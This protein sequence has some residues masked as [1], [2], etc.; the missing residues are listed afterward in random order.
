MKKEYADL[1]SILG[2]AMHSDYTEELAQPVDWH[3]IVNLAKLHK[4]LP[5]I[6]QTE[7]E[8]SS[9]VSDSVFDY[10]KE[11]TVRQTIAQIRKTELFN[12][13]YMKM[14][15]K[16]VFPLV[17]KGL[18][19]SE[20]YG[21]LADYRVSGD[22]DILVKK[23][24]FEKVDEL[25]KNEGFQPDKD[26]LSENQKS[27]I[28]EVTYSSRATDLRIEVHLNIMG[29]EDALR[30]KMNEYFEDVFS[31]FREID[32]DGVKFRTLT[33]T[34]HFLFIVF[35]ALKHMTVSGFGIRMVCD[36]LLYL[37]KYGEE[38]DLDYVYNALEEVNAVLFFE[39]LIYIGNKYLGFNLPVRGEKNCPEDLL[40]D[41]LESGI[42]GN[43]S[44]ARRT[45]VH[46]VHM[47]FSERKASSK[48][49]KAGLIFDSV[50]PTKDKFRESRPEID[51]KPWLIVSE[52]LKRI[53]RFL[54]HSKNSGGNLASESMKI[55]EQRIELLKKYKIL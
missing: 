50:F 36:I 3:S 25:L 53:G 24:D 46:M 48:F 31:V 13:L 12:Q 5:F 2:K 43:Y 54:S 28:Q 18:A 37:E 6:V 39:D 23:E 15:E 47:A 10:A 4:I 9:F 1:L 40:N 14:N 34:K 27:F 42:Y 20:L 19:C 8:N 49:G 22:E 16:G 32:S 17:M 55:G 45:S 44:Q 33:H 52:Y 21:K 7:M 51:E 29:T 11:V 38:I 30:I 41:I 26:N 35:H